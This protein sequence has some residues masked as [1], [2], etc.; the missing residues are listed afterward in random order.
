MATRA[1][2]R[3]QILANCKFL[4]PAPIQPN[5]LTI[6]DGETLRIFVVDQNGALLLEH[7]STNEGGFCTLLEMT[8]SMLSPQIHTMRNTPRKR[9]EEDTEIERL[10]KEVKE[11]RLEIQSLKKDKELEDLRWEN[12]RLRGLNTPTESACEW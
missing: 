5:L 4:F 7:H 3:D 1:F 10:S 8:E 9:I 12:A 2:Y 11:L 6:R